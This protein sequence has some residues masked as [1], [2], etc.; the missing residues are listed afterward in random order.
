M[1]GWLSNIAFSAV[2][3]EMSVRVTY[4]VEGTVLSVDFALFYPT[5][6]HVNWKF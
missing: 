4:Y 2:N 5:V 6:N 3:G 1:L